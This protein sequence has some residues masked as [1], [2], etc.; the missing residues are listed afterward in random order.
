MHLSEF[1]CSL[2]LS[3]IIGLLRLE[4][5]ITCLLNLVIG[6]LCSFIIMAAV[7]VF[8]IFGAILV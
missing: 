3:V 2:V 1:M 6:S 4:L 8:H 7:S 5:Q